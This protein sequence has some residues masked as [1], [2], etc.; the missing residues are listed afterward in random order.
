M[1]KTHNR[2]YQVEL[3]GQI[4]MCSPKGSFKQAE[5][6]FK[7]PVIGDRVRLELNKRR[8]Q[9]V[10][11]YIVEIMPRDNRLLRADADGRRE[12]VMAANLDL[13]LITCAVAQPGVDFALVDRYI[14]SCEL[15]GI[16]YAI[17]F[18]KIDL[19][20]EFMTDP[21]VLAYQQL[22]LPVLA[23]STKT[24]EGLEQLRE[25]VSEGIC[26]FSG[27][28]GAGKSSLINHLVPEAD[29][30]TGEVDPRKGRGRH[31]TT[32]SMLVPL[33]GGGYLVDSPGLR[34]FYPPKVPAEEVRFGFREIAALQAHCKF[35]SCLHVTEP[36][37][38]VVTALEAGILS[39]E[40][41]KSYLFL[42]SEMQNYS[43]NRFA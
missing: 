18:N 34:D 21:T 31:T 32:F 28:S 22:G 36:D 39:P 20:P 26:Y 13:L 23:T 30:T 12:R 4:Y 38:A 14:L 8:Q 24:G 2:F 7:L 43:Q 37:C 35:S 3:A 15:G 9:G 11:G 25:W 10:D 1:V 19:D 29:L 33:A 40:R 6:E 17:V 41:Y 27:P 5:S 42:L 16:D